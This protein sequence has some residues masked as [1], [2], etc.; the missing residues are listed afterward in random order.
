[1]KKKVLVITQAFGD[2]QVGDT[3]TD[4]AEIKA[5][6]EDRPSFVVVREQTDEEV[7]ADKRA[8][9]DTDDKPKK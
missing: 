8:G 1:V 9:A 4:A 5:L 2:R 3:I 6:M 7:E